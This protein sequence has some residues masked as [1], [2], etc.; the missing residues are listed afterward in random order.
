MKNLLRLLIIGFLISVIFYNLYSQNNG[1]MTKKSDTKT[2]LSLWL[3]FKTELLRISD[4]QD[5]TE[6][7]AALDK[8]WNHLKESNQIPFKAGNYAA[9]LYR[10]EADSIGFQGDFSSWGRIGTGGTD[11]VRIKNTDL[12]VLEK[13][14]PADA[15]L[16]YKIVINNKTWILDP[17]NPNI[18][19]S[20]FGANS[21]LRMPEWKPSPW[22]IRDKSLPAGSLSENIRM[23]SRFLNYDI[24]YRVYLPYGY[25][26]LKKL[27]VIYVTDGHEYSDDEKGSML[28]VLD[29]LIAKN[30]IKPVIAVFIDPRDPDSLSVNKRESQFLMNENYLDFVSDELVKRIDSLYKTGKSADSRAILGTSYGGVCATYFGLMRSNVFHLVG[31]Q[32]PAYWSAAKLQDIFKNIPKLPLKLFMSTGNINDGEML[33]RM[34]KGM[35]EQNNYTIMYKEVSEGHSWGNWRALLDDMLIYFWGL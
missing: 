7:N 29:N 18:Q 35:F 30:K 33:T 31:I 25:D 22:I 8:F 10:G 27:P 6:K 9:F 15:R 14:F 12:W 1:D 28:I 11:A 5:K 16:D 24:N 3:E 32:S 13:E 20:G 23:K 19:M 2:Q 34:V 17:N 26:H 21:E 4:M